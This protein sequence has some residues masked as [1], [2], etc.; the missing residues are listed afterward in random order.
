MPSTYITKEERHYFEKSQ[1]ETRV[2]KH[3]GLHPTSESR[4]VSSRLGGFGGVSVIQTYQE[5]NV[6]E[7][8]QVTYNEYEV[9]DILRDSLGLTGHYRMRSE[10][11]GE[12]YFIVKDL[13]PPYIPPKRSFWA[14]MKRILW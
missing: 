11:G 10:F 3:S 5:D 2:L 14:K 9:V 12:K 4:I 6:T 13:M 8:K 1:I 7:T